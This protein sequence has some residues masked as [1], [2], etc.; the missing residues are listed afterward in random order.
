M[1]TNKGFAPI[2]LV[3]IIIAV[4]AVGGIAYY[5]G[6]SSTVSTSATQNL[7][8]TNS[9]PVVNQNPNTSNTTKS[10]TARIINS[11]QNNPIG[12]TSTS[13]PYITV[14]APKTGAVLTSGHN[15][16][17]TWT[18]CNVQN[19]VVGLAQGGHDLGLFTSTPISAAQKFYQWAV[20]TPHWLSNSGF[21]IGVSDADACHGDVLGKSGTFSVQ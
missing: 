17:I 12:C 7:P 18:S 13:K 6:K 8:I 20:P 1:K 15:F 14:L 9:N 3:L 10:P 21:F 19:V 16:S 5:F 4:L 11:V 2:A